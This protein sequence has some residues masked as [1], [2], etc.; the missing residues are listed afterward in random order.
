[1]SYL[2]VKAVNNRQKRDEFKCAFFFLLFYIYSMYFHKHG[3]F[4]LFFME[5]LSVN[6]QSSSC[7]V[8]V[9]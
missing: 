4:G 2:Y 5:Q 6:P 9:R 7:V 3:N 8:R 1:M